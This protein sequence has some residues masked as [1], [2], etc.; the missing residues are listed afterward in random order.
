[1]I[2]TSTT[3]KRTPAQ[4]RRRRALYNASNWRTT[5]VLYA[6]TTD[7]RT[8]STKALEVLLRYA[9]AREW[10]VA[11]A[12]LDPSPLTTPIFEREH[13]AT[14]RDAITERRAEGIVA[15]RGHACEAGTATHAELSD[16]LAQRAAFLSVA[17]VTSRDRAERTPA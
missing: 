16:W 2:D 13:W 6:C 17:E 4:S 9:A 3:S 11:E 15:L 7:P 12:I 1:M 8:T 10:E 14:V 5:V